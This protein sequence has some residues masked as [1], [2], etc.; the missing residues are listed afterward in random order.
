MD[1][2][3]LTL[4]DKGFTKAERE[5]IKTVLI[6]AIKTVQGIAGKN[7]TINNSDNGQAIAASDC[8]PCP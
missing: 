5:W 2:N 1:L 7:V 3:T 6:P 4:P 8:Q